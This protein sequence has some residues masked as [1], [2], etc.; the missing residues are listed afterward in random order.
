MASCLLSGWVWHCRPPPSLP[1][2]LRL[3]V[4]QYIHHRGRG[5]LLPLLCLLRRPRCLL[6]LLLLPRCLLCQLRRL[7]IPP[8]PP[9]LLLGASNAR[10]WLCGSCGDSVVSHHRWLSWRLSWRLGWR[11]GRLGWRPC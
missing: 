2:I 3:T 9:R 1:F 7:Q 10:T 4:L 5:M 6:C 8:R 11:L